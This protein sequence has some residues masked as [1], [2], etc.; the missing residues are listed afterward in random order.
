ML[1]IDRATFVEW[2]TSTQ[3]ILVDVST[4]APAWFIVITN[5]QLRHEIFGLAFGKSSTSIVIPS[6]SQSQR[7]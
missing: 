2:V 6:V 4:L 7:T 3:F 5:K 1:T